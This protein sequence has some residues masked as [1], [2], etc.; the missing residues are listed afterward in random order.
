MSKD[1]A[2]LETKGP[3]ALT[4]PVARPDPAT[5]PLRGDIAHIALAGTY[6]VPHYVT[7]RPYRLLDGG[8]PLLR[9]PGDA[10]EPRAHL[11]G[12]S[13]FGVLDCEGAFAWG[14]VTLDG[15]VGWVALERLEQAGP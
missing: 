6:F 1:G 7:P 8:A 10:D 14:C 4:G 3:F 13:L 12:G 15:P 2:T 9:A 5:V 11:E